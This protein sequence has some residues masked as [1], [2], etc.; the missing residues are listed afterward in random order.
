MCPNHVWSCDMLDDQFPGWLCAIFP[1]SHAVKSHDT[2]GTGRSCD[3]S[4][5]GSCDRFPR[6]HVLEITWLELGLGAVITRL[7]LV[8]WVL[9][10]FGNAFLVGAS[11]ACNT[12][13]IFTYFVQSAI[14]CEGIGSIWRF[15]LDN[16]ELVPR[17]FRYLVHHLDEVKNFDF[18]LCTAQFHGKQI[19]WDTKSDQWKY[20]NNQKVHFQSPSTS[21]AEETKPSIPGE[22]KKEE[23]DNKGLDNEESDSDKESD[24]AHTP[25][26]DNT[27]KVD[28]LL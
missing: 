4:C 7:V 2:L 3:E 14:W 11:F 9:G 18:V 23:S 24:K 10:L 20:L 12:R 1:G 8:E 26:D 6:S 22:F 21:E 25:E 28:K 19:K 27:A 13:C 15:T 16:T 17:K 5:D